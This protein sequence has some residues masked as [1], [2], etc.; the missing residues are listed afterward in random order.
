ME[1]GTAIKVIRIARKL[2][3]S[4]LADQAGISVSLVSLIENGLRLPGIDTLISIAKVLD[5]PVTILWFMTEQDEM[6]RFSPMSKPI[7]A[8]R[9]LTLF[10]PLATA[11]TAMQ[12]ILDDTDTIEKQEAYEAVQ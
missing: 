1:L 9:V 6:E 3:Q 5:V 8:V 7:L 10:G 4:E 12:K 2:G 11:R